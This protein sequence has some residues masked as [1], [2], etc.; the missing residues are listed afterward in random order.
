[1]LL[2]HRFVE[3]AKRYGQKIAV[4]DYSTDKTL[5][6]RQTLIASLMLAQVCRK[7]ARGN[8][9]LM[10][11]T[12]L[13]CILA[14]LAILMS[15][16]VPVMINYS[17]GAEQNARYAQRKCAFHTII[18]S[19]ALLTKIDCAHVPGMV[20]LEDIMAGISWFDKL[21]AA[22]IALLPVSLIKLFIKGGD[23]NDNVVLLFTSGSELEP[24]TVPLTHK[25]ISTNILDGGERFHFTDQDILL[26][27]LP[28]FHVFGMTVSLWLPLF[29]GSTIVCLAN[30]LEYKKICEVA[31]KEKTT[32]MVGTPSF[33]WGYLRKSEEGDFASLRVSVCGADKCPD[34]LREGFF[35]KHGVT[36]LEGYGATEC[37][38]IISVNSI[39]EN[40][41]GSVG[42]PLRSIEV[43]I[44]NYETGEECAPGQDGRI[45]VKGGSVMKGYFNDFEQ[46]S[47]RMRNG[48]YDTGDMGN[49]DADG[50]LWH[51]GRLKRFVKIG[52]EM[53]S[54]VR[55]ENALEKLLPEDMECCV[56]EVPDAIKGAKIVAVITAPIEE[57]AITKQLATQL[58]PIAIPKIFLVREKMPKTGNGKVDFQALTEIAR[59]ELAR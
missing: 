49:I 24:K 3:I 46:T 55:I 50:Y 36:L 1:M 48:W 22:S 47:L 21:R 54:M 57:K 10:V 38:P 37:S 11:P 39:E 31:R 52:G 28:Y 8:I 15:G 34:G 25:N 51:V 42:K 17:T 45:L 2:H 33:Y 30:P 26:A 40:R 58:S 35:T 4:R 6:Y 18:T 43:R 27:T 32:V 7:F 19:K 12:S 20:Y 44:E 9:G 53:I 29:Y 23:E 5:T 16:R 14:K 59:E 41:P 13:G 56:V